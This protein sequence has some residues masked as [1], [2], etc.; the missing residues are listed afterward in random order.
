MAGPIE[1]LESFGVDT[2]YI[3]AT[4][5]IVFGIGAFILLGLDSNAVLS[6]VTASIPI[7]LPIVTFSLF[8]HS[9]MEYVHKKY[10]LA[11]GRVTLEIKIPQ[12]VFKSPEAM[13]LVLMQLYQTAS[14]D[15]H[16]QTYWDG[17]NP[18][19]HALELVSRGGDVRFYMNVVRKKFK[20][21]T[22]T[23]LYAQYPGIEVHELDIDYTA[24]IPW[25][26]SRF[27]YFSL[28]FGLKKADAYPI[29]TYIDYG[30]D[31]LP[32]EEEKIDPITTLL[33][34]LGSIGPGEYI[35]MQ[36]L[37]TANRETDF[38]TGSLGTVPD[39]KGAARAEIKNIITKAAKRVGVEAA[40]IGKNVNQFLTDAERDTIKAIERSL[41]KVAFN[42]VNRT[43][44]IAKKGSFMPGERISP[45]ITGWRA[46]DDLNR[47]Q[48][49]FK[50]RT[51]FD[52]NWW[53]DPSG[54]KR[55]HYKQQELDEYKRRTYTQ[56]T[57]KDGPGVCT[58]EELA[59][60]FHIP[61][62]VAATPTLARIP[63][64]RAEAPSNLPVSS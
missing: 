2:T 21:M 1:K 53:Q 27:D 35:W 34:M 60:I 40:D 51:D 47:N 19:V 37:I 15:N 48:I 38:K 5:G 61:G 23:N 30:L 64:K 44:Y 49:G 32:K 41:G 57:E 17:K 62:K 52:W 14:P 45:I 6:L 9:W 50:W 46:F 4:I 13:E 63:S 31:K 56:H 20:N 54:H 7:W 10:N 33:E 26:T 55:E 42:M 43:M 22:E 59:T 18:P 25:D 3:L 8:F 11:Q 28:H 29:K 36:T 16:I 12:D 58:T 24:E 39:W